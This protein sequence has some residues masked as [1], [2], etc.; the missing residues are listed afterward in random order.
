MSGTLVTGAWV[1]VDSD[2]IIESGAVYVENG[3]VVEIGSRDQMLRRH[4]DADSIG[5]SDH[6]LL[7]GFVNG[8]GHGKGL[9]DFQRGQID[10]TLETW[11]FRSY[12]P[13]E[14]YAD[15]R[16]NAIKLLEAGVTTTMHTHAPA[17][18]DAPYEEF[19][20]ILQAY[21]DTGIRVAFSPTF[22]NCNHFV[23]GDNE[24]FLSGLPEDLEKACRAFI[25]RGAAF[26]PDEYM[27]AV[28]ALHA[29]RDGDR[30]RIMHGPLA[31]QW[32]DEETLERIRRDADERGLRI[33]IHVQQTRFQRLYGCRRYGKSLIARLAD[34]GFLG[35][36]VT[37]GHAVWVSESDIDRLAES[38]ASV[39]HHAACN[40]RVRNGIA[41][42]RE[43]LIRGV[44]VAVGMD[45]KE[46]GDDK[47]F[48][49]EMRLIS[50]LH[51]VDS[52]RLDSPQLLPKEVLKMGTATGAEV[53]GFGSE[54]GSLEPG[55]RADMVLLDMSRVSEPFV[56]PGHS[57]V[58][59]LIYRAG[60]RDVDM[61]LVDGEVVVR[62]GQVV[63]IDRREAAE[64]LRSSL[65][66]NYAE[67]FRRKN[68]V[69]KRLRPSIAAWF[70]RMNE[71]KDCETE[72]GEV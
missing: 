50:K 45:D 28:S 15:A 49:E 7:P 71:R 16:W 3:R 24:E 22:S 47:D 6:L 40:L 36:D 35:P 44:P 46:F 41:P 67:E 29:E 70:E 33:H 48:I 58:D 17:N 4:P 27:D 19:T 66:E 61:V 18:P 8:H 2:R 10:D 5:T 57:P 52:T 21:G 31:P 26:G 30:V 12:P 38:G 1:V 53:L 13:V 56:H 42:V 20:A 54:V 72:G 69:W 11:K 23:Y 34:T 51:R 60:T 63:H 14:P 64:R 59:L 62:G 32:V 37:V 68:E 65:P 9:T 39:T 55:K 25:A 43:M